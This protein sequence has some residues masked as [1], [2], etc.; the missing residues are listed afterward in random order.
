MSSLKLCLSPLLVHDRVHLTC[1]RSCHGVYFKIYEVCILIGTIAFLWCLAGAFLCILRMHE[2]VIF[3]QDRSSLDRR[4]N[5][6]QQALGC[7][8]LSVRKWYVNVSVTAATR[9]LSDEDRTKVP[10]EGGKGI[11]YKVPRNEHVVSCEMNGVT[12]A[13]CGLHI[14]GNESRHF[15]L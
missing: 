13:V 10:K 5:Y 6:L 11:Q 15:N 12:P 2:H 1:C 7:Y 9:R 14:T 8:Y 3:M 4:Q